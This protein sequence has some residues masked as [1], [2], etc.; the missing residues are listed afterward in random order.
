MIDICDGNLETKRGLFDAL[1]EQTG[2]NSF[3]MCERPTNPLDYAATIGVHHIW[4]FILSHPDMDH[5]DGLDALVRRLGVS[6]FWDTGSR[7]PKPNFDNCPYKEEDWE[8]YERIRDG[9]LNVLTAIRQAGARFSFANQDADGTGGGD[10]LHILSPDSKLID[11]PNTEDDINE[12]SYVV[13]YLTAGKNLIFPGDAHDVSWEYIRKHEAAS[14]RNCTFLLAPHHGRDAG[15]S[16]EFLDLLQPK[17]TLIGCSPSKYIDYDQWYRRKLDII[18]SNQ[19]GNVVLEASAD[20]I[21][22]YIENPA[23]AASRGKDLKLVNSQGYIY[24][25]T[26]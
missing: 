23:F 4:R 14:V 1:I 6:N 18:T 20:R 24:F 12:G 10:G 22:I 26:L 11:D 16:Y 2:R 8:T 17:L 19:C 15:R 5:M 9:T 21:H 25:T 13:Q 3:R 7:R